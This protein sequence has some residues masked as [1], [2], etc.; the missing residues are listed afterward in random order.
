MRSKVY[1]NGEWN[2]MPDYEGRASKDAVDNC[3]WADRKITV[4]SS[5][6]TALWK[7]HEYQ[8][9]NLFEYP[10]E[11]NDANSGVLGRTF[12][13]LKKVNENVFLKLNGVLQRSEVYI[14]GTRVSQS[15]E[16]FL[17]QE[18]DI[19]EF[20]IEG[21]KNEIKVWCGNFD[22]VDIDTGHK[23]LA[24]CGSWFGGNAR[25]IW[26]DI[27][28]EYRAPL[29][30]DNIQVVTST[31]KQEISIKA[32]IK[33]I[34][35]KSK[36][37]VR[38]RIVEGATV[39]KEYTSGFYDFEPGKEVF[40]TYEDKWSDASLWSPENPNLYNILVEV[41]VDNKAVD[42]YE[43]KFGFREF[44]IEDYKFYLNGIR[45]NLRTDSW[46]YQ[47]FVQQNKEYAFNWYKA[48]RDM[49]CNAIR[50]HAM[51]Y[52]ELYLEVA[53]EFGMLII[54]E[55]AIY[56]SGKSFRADHP[57]FI[58]N[59]HKHLQALVLRDRNHPCVINWSMQNEMRW[60]EGREG[61]K[62]AMKE[63]VK[64][65]KTLDDTRPISFDGD[66]RL[67]DPEDMEI[68]SMHYNIDGTVK[69]WDKKKPLAFGEHGSFHYISP[70]VATAFGG[71]EVY[72]SFE[73][74]MEA[75]GFEE[76]LFN[77]YARKEE[78][79]AVSPFNMANYMMRSMPKEDIH[80]KWEDLSTPGVKPSVIIKHSLTINNGYVKNE[81][82]Y[83]PND[84][85]KMV[86]ESLGK[87]T[88]LA[89]EYNTSFFG[90]KKVNRNFSIYND[91]EGAAEVKLVYM[92]SID[93]KVMMEGTESFIHNPGER[94]SWG[95]EFT[96]PEVNIRKLSKLNLVLYHGD[97]I[98]H[99]LE[100]NYCIY[101]EVLNCEIIKNSGKKIAYCGN[102]ESYN[103]IS[104]LVESIAYIDNY[105]E[106]T[107]E[108]V[109]LLIIGNNFE[110]RTEKLQHYLSTFVSRGGFVIILEQKA[111][112]PGDITLS[113]K[114]FFSS[115]I[116]DKESLVF[117]GLKNEDL[118]FWGEKNINTG[119]TGFLV[120]NAFN[121]PMNG[122]LKILLEC[123]EGNFG[124]GGL[125]WTPLIE[126]TIG[127]GKMLLNQI[128]IMDNMEKIPQA[129]I[130]LRN[131]LDYGI[132]Y[133]A[134]NKD[135][136]G[137]IVDKNSLSEQFVED[138]GIEYVRIS[139]DAMKDYASVIVDPD[140]LHLENI[141]VFRDFIEAGSKLFILP[142]NTQHTSLLESLFN[143]KVEI[144]KQ[145]TYQIKA[146]E[147]ELTRGILVPDLYYY[148]KVSYSPANK[149][150]EVLCSHSLNLEGVQPLFNTVKNPWNDYFIKNLESE[151]IKIGIATMNQEAEFMPL[152]YGAVKNIGK[153][154]AILCQIRLCS[155][156]EKIKRVYNRLFCNAKIRSKLNMLEYTKEKSDYAIQYFMALPYE[157]HNDYNEEEAYF[158]ATDYALNNLGEGVYGWMQRLEKKN[159]FITIPDSAG[160][161]YFMTIFI[162]SDINR[163]PEKRENNELPDS[164]IV[165]DAFI[166][167][168]CQ[169]KLVV[170][171]RFYFEST[172]GSS[173]IIDKKVE[174]IVFSKGVNRLLLVCKGGSEDIKL[175]ICLKNKY[176]D[177]V[178]GLKY[179]CT[180]D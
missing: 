30:I 45:I 100:K 99:I 37:K 154:R 143:S 110:G 98:V 127:K 175:N 113:G 164:S 93:G 66:N 95:I 157:K 32:C 156:N 148:E 122:D 44:W 86:Q 18:I 16:G 119:D 96:F 53:D 92:F 155:S 144:L 50:L 178:E 69:D 180:L 56:G 51:P 76:R 74:C 153:G 11:W 129:L 177:F 77:E 172:D 12:E 174:D 90:G 121:K 33:N 84:A 120:Q 43:T 130:L 105:N 63:L 24:P 72:E 47:G 91:T 31:R 48:C 126:Y 36:A 88:I 23:F 141:K 34:N 134:V 179:L 46:H 168:N 26:Q 78:V 28:L 7:D 3:I 68:V 40:V 14:N 104:T 106:E 150:N 87:I 140:C 142:V 167:S 171:G 13:V 139:A 29:Y 165:P 1:L 160:K 8:S 61:Y 135:I 64:T 52:P 4:P 17:P 131:M 166:S 101:P 39:V 70:Q 6:K 97:K 108:K 62:Q 55:S 9:Y 60:I 125:L 137:V 115:Y 138:I 42:A 118:C 73:K 57:V 49:G 163:D 133:A 173:Q 159:G 71:P 107:L 22:A 128:E 5:W 151:P 54:D 170:N 114:K 158:T 15:N 94:Q 161:L 81:E 75:I 2:F 146:M 82:S 145:D 147:D 65:M 123:G 41:L 20:V 132:R 136:V 80:L 117:K 169:L 162:D 124:W 25:G 116:A 152:C 35:T 102:R 10:I 89:D 83:I 19:T 85:F 58:E 21:Y 27:F 109:D 149:T 176:G 79:T 112:A 38:F 67:V 111:F 59:C 103:I